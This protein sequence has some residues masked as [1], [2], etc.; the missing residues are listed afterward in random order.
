MFRNCFWLFDLEFEFMY[1]MSTGQREWNGS[2]MRRAWGIPL[3]SVSVSISIPSTNINLIK[4][5]EIHS[6]RYSNHFHIQ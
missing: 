5:S 1:E 4:L 3:G 6:F 2:Y